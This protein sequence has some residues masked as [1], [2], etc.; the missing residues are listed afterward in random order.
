MENKKY[1]IKYDIATNFDPEFIG[2]LKN[3][4]KDN[5]VGT[6]FGKLRRDI[7]GGGRSSVNSPELSLD[8]LKNYIKD[9]HDNNFKFNYLINTTCLG[10]RE[11]NPQYHR[12][13]VKYISKLCELGIDGVTVDYPYLCQLIKKQFP[14][15][16]VSIGIGAGVINCKQI[17]YWR[18]MGADEITVGHGINRNFKLLEEILTF[19]KG[20]NMNIRLIANNTCLPECPSKIVHASGHSHAS[21]KR[22]SSSDLYID[23][24]LLYCNNRRVKNMGYMIASEWIRPEDVHYYEEI[25][26]KVGNHNFSLKLLERT[27]NTEFLLRVAKAYITKN[28]EGNLL[29]ILNWPAEKNR[30]V[31]HKKSIIFRTII[32]RYNIKK[33]LNYQKVFALPNVYIDNKKLNGFLDKFKVKYD[34]SSKMCG[35]KEDV[36]SGG[37]N[38]CC[39]CS[40]WAEKAI[41]YNKEEIDEWLKRSDVL[42]NSMRNSDFF[43]R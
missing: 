30:N 12:K 14:N 42:I 23:Y 4:D 21:Q 13:M 6:V 5:Q 1:K 29:D 38:I 17:G 35:K 22:N 2:K 32:S 15:L 40:S 34:C 33:L 43:Q 19:T 25:C 10:N 11:V 41:S 39:Y 31:I 8:E 3:I 7:I 16:M 28:F 26:D 9:C 24:N 27:K 18:E 36:A 37:S 20:T